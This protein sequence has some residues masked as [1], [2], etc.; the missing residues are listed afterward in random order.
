MRQVSLHSYAICGRGGFIGRGFQFQDGKVH[1]SETDGRNVAFALFGGVATPADAQTIN[2]LAHIPGFWL[3][4]VRGVEQI[5]EVLRAT[6]PL[7][8][9]PTQMVAIDQG[10]AR[11]VHKQAFEEVTVPA[12]GTITAL[13]SMIS[14]VISGGVIVGAT[15]TLNLNGTT[16]TI[17]NA[18]DTRL[19]GYPGLKVANN[20]YPD[21]RICI[22]DDGLWGIDQN[23]TVRFQ[24]FGDGTLHLFDAG[25][26]ER[27]LLD[28]LN[29]QVIVTG[30]GVKVN[31]TFITVP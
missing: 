6:S 19:L 30:L 7:I 1:T 15:L 24:L 29:G 22:V 3:D 8:G 14:P 21:R 28:G 16:V 25:G 23:N 26:T 13:V 10:G 31:G 9:G 11:W 18:Y 27:V 2:A 12:T 5:I 17:D 4:G 20:A